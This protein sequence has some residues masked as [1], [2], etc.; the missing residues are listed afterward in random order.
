MAEKLQD[1]KDK[2]KKE[3]EKALEKVRADSRNQVDSVKNEMARAKAEWAR[4]KKKMG[5]EYQESLS[6]AQRDADVQKDSDI[7]SAREKVDKSW[8]K[9]L[10]EREKDF[11]KQI[12]QLEEEDRESRERH[13]EDLEKQRLRIEA[14]LTE[15]IKANL[16]VEVTYEI[17]DQMK[18]DLQEVVR[19]HE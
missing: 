7:V 2:I 8:R 5:I 12:T 11:D 13:R 6:V 15:K 16:R 1:G 3:K 10:E 19:A 9:R 4:D 17:E 18:I 14:T